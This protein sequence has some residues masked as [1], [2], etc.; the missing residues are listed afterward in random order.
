MKGGAFLFVRKAFSQSHDLS[1]L[2][3]L[4]IVSI[5]NL[6]DTSKEKS[7][8][9][10]LPSDFIIALRFVFI[11]AQS[12]KTQLQSKLVLTWSYIA[13]LSTA[14]AKGARQ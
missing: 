13:L 14:S 8:Q 1:Q 6:Y 9:I 3:K 4:I 2:I 5:I 10:I 12:D 7:F 11:S